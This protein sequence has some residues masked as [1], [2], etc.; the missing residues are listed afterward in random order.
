MYPRSHRVVFVVAGYLSD[1]VLLVPYPMSCSVFL[2][3]TLHLKQSPRFHPPPPR[4]L[5][6]ALPLRL[7]RYLPLARAAPRAILPWSLC[8]RIH[9]HAPF[10]AYLC[11][12]Q[13][14]KYNDKGELK[15]E[16]RM[17]IATVG[18]LLVPICLFW[19]G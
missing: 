9:R 18:A 4:H 10:F 14:P 1:F 5:V 7:F 11:Y 12:V 6:R 17:P 19:F 3:A 13:E 15:L 2:C 16:E 8:R